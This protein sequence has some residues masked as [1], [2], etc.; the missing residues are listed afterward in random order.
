MF[1][2]P[3]RLP[4]TLAATLVLAGI[5]HG[6]AGMWQTHLIETLQDAQIVVHQQELSSSQQLKA[7]AAIALSSPLAHVL[8]LGFDRI[9]KKPSTVGQFLGTLVLVFFGTQAGF[10]GCL[11][12][13]ARVSLPS[14]LDA[15]AVLGSVSVNLSELAPDAWALAG[16]VSA[17]LLLAIVGS[18]VTALETEASASSP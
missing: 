6:V 1:S 17:A 11:F 14:A 18:V 7:A 13:T 10:A 15:S 16:G 9:S 5:G 8:R 12:A 2:R 3:L 4:I